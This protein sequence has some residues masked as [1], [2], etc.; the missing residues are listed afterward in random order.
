VI[1]EFVVPGPRRS[2]EV[3]CAAGSCLSGGKTKIRIDVSSQRPFHSHASHFLFHGLSEG[4]HAHFQRRSLAERTEWKKGEQPQLIRW[5][6]YLPPPSL[7]HS[8][9][10]DSFNLHP[11]LHKSVL[12]SY[13]HLNPCQHS[14]PLLVVSTRPISLPQPC[15]PYRSPR[16]P[17]PPIP[18]NLCPPRT[19]PLIFP[20]PPQ[21]PR[22]P[23]RPLPHLHP[24]PALTPRTTT[25]ISSKPPHLLSSLAQTRRPPNPS[26]RSQAIGRARACRRSTTR[27]CLPGLCRREKRSGFP[28][29]PARMGVRVR[30]QGTM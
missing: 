13:H 29:A 12:H 6:S 5:I 25:H 7:I 15:H 20:L 22:L 26:T 30:V 11:P 21:P 27:G 9:E 4:A 1:P 18:Q 17:P 28:P 10:L 2:S 19:R 23:L 24:T 16:L 3:R 8:H 14:P